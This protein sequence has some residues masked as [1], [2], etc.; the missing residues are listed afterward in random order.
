M[1]GAREKCGVSGVYLTEQNG[2]ASALDYDIL[3]QLY[4]RGHEGAGIVSYDHSKGIGVPY[5]D[6]GRIRDIFKNRKIPERL[7]GDIAIGHTRYGTVGLDK[8]DLYL[9]P[10]R[11]PN[12]QFYLAH[13]GTITPCELNKLATDF[14]ADDI[15]DSQIL[16]ALFEKELTDTKR[17]ETALESAS[18]F[19]DGSYT[20]T[21]LTQDGKLIGVRG[22]RGLKPLN[23]GRLTC[24][25]AI[26]S[27]T[28]A[29]KTIGA[30]NITSVQPGEVVLIDENGLEKKK[31]AEAPISQCSFEHIYFSN[32][33]SEF[34]GVNCFNVRVAAGRRL[35]QKF[36]IDADFVAPIPE[37]G[38]PGALGF[39]WESGIPTTEAIVINREVGR[40]FILPEAE[41]EAAIRCKYLPIEGAIR[42]KKIVLIDDSIVRADTTGIIV[43]RLREA[44][45]KEV[46]VRILYYPISH[47]CIGG[48][49]AFAHRNKLA[50]NKFGSVEGI[51]DYINATSLGFLSPGDLEDIGIKNACFA[52][53]TGDYQFKEP[54]RQL[55][56][57]ESLGYVG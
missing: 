24:G 41:R 7:G 43:R 10:I 34:G 19:L 4:H 16:A 46:H 47:P 30:E 18:R 36:P 45:A 48:G 5:K 57:A 52:C 20:C 17:W 56:L 26:A 12:G 51:R 54:E 44:G 53:G 29:L 6:V 25:Y 49:V 55:D 33:Q 3:L 23:Y 40:A 35:A 38:R 9:H 1:F 37:S 31:F 27:E 50:I 13:N 28:S 15:F 39:S 42:G 32:V 21:I 8:Q 11:S 14:H 2:S 22:P